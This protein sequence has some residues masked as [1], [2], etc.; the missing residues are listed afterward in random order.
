MSDCIFFSDS[1]CW[2]H[3]LDTVFTSGSMCNACIGA[4]SL[5]TYNNFK[6]P[7]GVHSRVLL[8]SGGMLQTSGYMI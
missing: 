8:M 4:M 2:I 3:V 5:G 7:L 1:Q 6:I